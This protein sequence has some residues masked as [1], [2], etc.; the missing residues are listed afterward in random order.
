MAVFEMKSEHSYLQRMILTVLNCFI[1]NP[2][3]LLLCH[4]VIFVWWIVY[5]YLSCIFSLLHLHLIWFIV[6]SMI[7]HFSQA[8][9]STHFISTF[10]HDTINVLALFS[11][12]FLYFLVILSISFQTFC[13]FCYN[14]GLISP[15]ISLWF[16]AQHKG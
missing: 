9:S 12:I 7:L 16:K 13:I 3:I 15:N 1:Y 6:S 14:P 8:S 2:T 5:F 10:S 4:L 11:H